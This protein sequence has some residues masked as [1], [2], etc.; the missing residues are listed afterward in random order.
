MIRRWLRG[1]LLP[2]AL[3]LTT[4]GCTTTLESLT[5]GLVGGLAPAAGDEQRPPRS[6]ELPTRDQVRLCLDAGREMDR[7]HNDEGSLDQYERVL[8]LDPSNFTAMRRLCVLYDRQARWDQAEAMYKKIAKIKPKDADIWSDWGYSFYLRAGKKNWS[9][10][11]NKL[12]Y[13]LQLDPQHARAHTNLGMVL[14]HLE[15]YGEAYTE[16]R[17]AQL[18]EAEA[19]CDIAFVYWSQGKMDQAKHECRT[20]RE[21]DSSCLKARDMLAALEKGPPPPE[22][23]R[24]ASGRRTRAGTLT[25]AQWD[26]EHEAARKAVA[27][28]NGSGAA[29]AGG[30]TEI[31]QTAATEK[32]WQTGGPITMPNGTRWMPVNPGTPPKLPSPPPPTPV[33][34]GTTGMVTFD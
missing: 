22:A 28:M 23:E 2:S 34:A 8:S 17:A 12:R 15:R 10:A 9:E 25:A 14:G 3:C 33:P 13:A 5:G 26:A 16:F 18:S 19:H 32:P 27:D 31:Q 24:T 11:E 6:D 4:V 21:M 20:A 30:I 7:A 1:C 29:P